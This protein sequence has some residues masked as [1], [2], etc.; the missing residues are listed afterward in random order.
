MWKSSW[1]ER[2]CT[3]TYSHPSQFSGVALTAG[4]RRPYTSL[5]LFRPGIRVALS[6]QPRS[7]LR[8]MLDAALAAADPA[9]CVPPHL[10]ALPKGRTVVVGA[11]KAAAAMARAVELNWKG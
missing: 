4:V 8:Q 9:I 7:L 10:P 1:S 2:T 11:G 5:R 3:A 6:P